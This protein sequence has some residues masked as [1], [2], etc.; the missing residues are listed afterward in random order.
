MGPGI[1]LLLATRINADSHIYYLD[2]IG[3]AS[4]F[5]DISGSENE[6]YEY[7]AWGNS[8][9]LSG[10]NNSMLYKRKYYDNESGMYFNRLRQYSPT[11]GRFY[12]RDV[13]LSKNK[14]ISF[15]N[16]PINLNDLFGLQS[17]ADG[18]FDCAPSCDQYAN[19][20]CW[21][22][23]HDCCVIRYIIDEF[24]VTGLDIAGAA[25]HGAIKGV[26]EA[27]GGHFAE[28]FLEEVLMQC[29]DECDKI[30][31]TDMSEAC[32]QDFP[33]AGCPNNAPGCDLIY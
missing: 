15:S 4:V 12:S 24:V 3:N 16:N 18:A 29:F 32:F 33:D 31:M 6:S 28:E 11:L 9:I 10:Q 7:D 2:G 14:Y 30:Y 26:F 22:Q 17:C 1:D 8:M 21:K 20:Y 5:S 19:S 13:K 25:Y 27:L 23:C